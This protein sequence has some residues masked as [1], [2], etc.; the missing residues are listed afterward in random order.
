M[1]GLL[2]RAGLRVNECLTLRV[3]HLDFEANRI[4]VVDG[5]GKKDRFTIIPARLKQTLEDHLRK[6]KRVHDQ[7]LADGWGSV[8]L[9][10]AHRRSAIYL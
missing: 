1:A 3:T 9:P 2:Y 5:K 8:V 7:D 4:F 10:H 6:V